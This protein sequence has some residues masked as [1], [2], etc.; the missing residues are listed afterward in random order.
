MSFE[1]TGYGRRFFDSQFPDLIKAL[2][3]IATA[4]EEA[5]KPLDR[6]ELQRSQSGDT[7]RLE[8]AAWDAVAPKLQRRRE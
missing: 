6:T 7:S 4:L 5:V 8:R 2:E 1:Q 3:R